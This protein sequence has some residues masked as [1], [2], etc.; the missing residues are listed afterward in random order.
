[1][2]GAKKARDGNWYVPNP[3]SPGKFLKVVQ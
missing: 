1:V 3:N 2:Q